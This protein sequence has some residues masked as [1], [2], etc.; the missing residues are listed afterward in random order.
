MQQLTGAI[1]TG[2]QARRL[3][4]LGPTDKGLVLLQQRPLVAWVAHRLGQVVTQ[5]P[6]L[7]SANQNQQQ[8]Q[9]YGQVIG[10]PTLL[11]PFQ[12]PLAGLWALLEHCTTNWLLVS[13]VDTPFVS[14]ALFN[15]LCGARQ[16]YPQARALFMQH[17]RSYPLCLLIHRSLLE[18]LQQAV[19]AGE[20]RV[21]GWLAQQQAVAV[22][23]SRYPDQCFYNIN[24]PEDIKSAQHWA[25]QE[26]KPP[27]L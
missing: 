25:L 24:T 27:L 17:E 11:P 12:G 21:H 5:T 20:R 6:L 1:L 14:T 19:L 8:Y 16:M 13:P 18:P 22:D 26:S 15:E 9:R 7:I 23:V 2:G 10:D 4:V 3:Q